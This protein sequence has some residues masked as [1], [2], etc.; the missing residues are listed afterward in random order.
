MGHQTYAN[1][2]VARVL[3]ILDSLEKLFIS[4]QVM[5]DKSYYLRQPTLTICQLVQR[6]GFHVNKH[7]RRKKIY[8]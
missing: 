5:Q 3:F 6:G 1:E 4:L 8:I 2:W 7:V